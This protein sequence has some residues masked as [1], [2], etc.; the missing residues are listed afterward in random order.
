MTRPRPQLGS[1]REAGFS[2]LEIMIALAIMALAV[3]LVG[4][5]F[6]RSSAGFRFDAA[7]QD[8][9]LSL[10][11]AQ[12]RALR[13]GREVSVSIDVDARRYQLQQDSP[14]DLPSGAEVRVVSAG[15]VMGPDRRP[16]FTFSPDGGSSGGT[17]T[18]TE[19]GRSATIMVDWLTGSVGMADGGEN[20]A[21]E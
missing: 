8:L 11:E 19:Q 20:A 1:R 12:A 5:A 3:S 10:R 9:A 14:V 18:L 21:T 4:V 6:A 17:I 15:Q 2:L 7:T 16:V 13:S